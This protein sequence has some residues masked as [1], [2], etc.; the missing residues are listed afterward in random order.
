MKVRGTRWKS[1]GKHEF[2][3]ARWNCFSYNPVDSANPV[4]YGL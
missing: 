4:L 2:H 1:M 3:L